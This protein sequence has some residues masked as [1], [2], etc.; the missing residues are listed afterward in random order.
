MKQDAI[1]GE[2]ALAG[3]VKMRGEGVAESGFSDVSVNG[4]APTEDFDEPWVGGGNPLDDEG[5]GGEARGERGD[6]VHR[7]LAGEQQVMDDGKHQDGVEIADGAIEEGG[8]LLIFPAN[9][10][11]GV[12][13]INAEGKNVSVGVGGFYTEAVECSRVQVD[14]DDFRADIG[15][16]AGVGAGVAA[17][18]EQAI[19]TSFIEDGLDEIELFVVVY[20]GVVSGFFGVVGPD[21]GAA[22]GSGSLHSLPEGV[23]GVG[24]DVFGEVG[25]FLRACGALNGC[26]C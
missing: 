23:E 19:G 24:D 1:V 25:V 14:G 3:K 10:G 2:C 18:V 13:D 22:H 20:G 7:N 9:G 16:E 6:V 26:G 11:R 8:A 4:V 15:G 17:D 12:G 5:A 21:G